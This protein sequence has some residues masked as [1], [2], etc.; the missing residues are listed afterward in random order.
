MVEVERALKQM[1]SGKAAGEDGIL[2]EFLK[3]GK[4]GCGRLW[5]YYLIQYGAASMCRWIGEE[6]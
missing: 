5:L 4:E 2:T 1:K 6:D 3:E